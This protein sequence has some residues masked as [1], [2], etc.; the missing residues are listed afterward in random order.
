MNFIDPEWAWQPFQPDADRPWN[1]RRAAHLFRRAAFSGTHEELAVAVQDGIEP[2][3]E[4]I[5]DAG[6][7]DTGTLDT[8]AA[9]SF[10]KEMDESARYLIT[11]GNVRRLSSWW[12]LRMANSPA[13]L[14]EK[15][16]LFWHGH[17]ATSGQKVN[18]VDAMLR[19]NQ[20]LRE[21]ALGKFEPLVQ[22]IS[23]D[24]AM[25][26]YLDSTNNRKTR[27]NEN[28]ARELLELFCLGLDNYTE[29]DI[30][31]IARCFT[32]WEVR[33]V[34][35]AAKFKFNQQQHDE[36]S[37]SFF[38]RSGNLGGEEA[39][40]IVLDQPAAVRFIARKLVRF[41]MFDDAA[42]SDE[43][44][45]PVAET[46]RQNDFDVSPALRLIFRSNLFYSDQVVAQKIRGPVELVVGNDA[47]TGGK[48]QYG[49]DARATGVTGPTAVVS[50]ECQRLGRRPQMVKCVDHFGSRQP[51]STVC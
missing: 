18:D 14:L 47:A 21:H 5:L 15:M 30:K 27:P 12:L 39:V 25:L 3:I 17:F 11:G 49:T 2:T 36:S 8:G 13:P 28:Y 10:G 7:S 45:E 35:G 38:G 19:Q 16:T 44:I 20:L 26:T 29:K 32:G 4:K 48:S 51:H 23:R 9:E 6:T 33:K 46:L 37:K 40:Q 31:E 41:F 1:R 42:I 22:G 43:L 34:S 24:V 50:A